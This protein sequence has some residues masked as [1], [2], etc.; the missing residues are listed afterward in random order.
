MD[1]YG[2]FQLCSIGI[3]AAPV[4]V[5]LSSTYFNNP[6]RNTIFLWTSLVLAG[7]LALTVE[8]SRINAWPCDVGDGNPSPINSNGSYVYADGNRCG[9]ICSVDD[10]PSSPMRGGSGNNIYVIPEP[11]TLTIGTAMLLS[12]G[13]CIPA[14]LSMATMWD[15]ILE[16]NWRSRFGGSN[17]DVNETFTGANGDTVGNMKGI[18]AMM[19]EFL[20]VVEIPVF[21]GA[22]LAILI[23]GE[24]NLWSD[25]VRYQTEPMANVGTLGSCTFIC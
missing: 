19:R 6:G 14:I 17:R 15:K 16:I 4:T 23:I 20:S 21:G 22:V 11:E 1:V 3:L 25:Q 8:F 18:N 12:A 2:A 13:C 9:L 7:L 10:G 24:K 5:R